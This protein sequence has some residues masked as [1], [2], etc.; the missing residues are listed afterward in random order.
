[1]IIDRRNR[2]TRKK[3]ASS[4]LYPPQ[5]WHDLIWDRTGAA[6]VGNRRLTA[7]AVTTASSILSLICE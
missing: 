3:P 4:P 1:M 6:A 5:I 7:W 2:S